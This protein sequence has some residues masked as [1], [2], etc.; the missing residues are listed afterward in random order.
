MS[1][2]ASPENSALREIINSSILTSVEMSLIQLVEL[3]LCRYKDLKDGSINFRDVI[4]LLEYS[5]IKTSY[6]NWSA[7]RAEQKIKSKQFLR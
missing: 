6:T 7:Q 2:E 5:K 4:K 3:G 1:T